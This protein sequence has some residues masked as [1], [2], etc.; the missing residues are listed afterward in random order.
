[1]KHALDPP[2]RT[3]STRTKAFL[4]GG[5]IALGIA[6]VG[7]VVFA[8]FTATTGASGS[9]VSGTVTLS[10]ISTN[11]AGNRLTV[12][13][14]NIAPGDTVQRAVTIQNTGSIDLSGITLTTN[15]T[16]SSLLDT[17]TTT[18]LQMTVDRCSVGWTESAFPYT[19]TCS[20]TTSTVLA[21]TAVIGA[22]R[23]LANLTLTA[24]ATN[25]LRVTLTL[26]SAAG[27]T[28]QGQTSA[29]NY[30]FTA[31]QRAGTAR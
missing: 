15:A 12:A 25:N 26:P 29:I 27:N 24:S 19:Y 31:T 22:N 17:D 14:T 30:T 16:T 28:L 23:T 8:A 5:L 2:P 3:M 1:M 9:A 11:A 20:G 4:S 13:A 18:G 10:G 21:S 6:G 7:G